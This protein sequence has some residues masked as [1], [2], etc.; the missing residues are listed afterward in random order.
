MNKWYRQGCLRSFDRSRSLGVEISSCSRSDGNDG[1]YLRRRSHTDSSQDTYHSP[2]R[3]T[4]LSRIQSYLGKASQ[5][6][7]ELDRILLSTSAIITSS[8][9]KTNEKNL[10]SG[11]CGADQ[12]Q[13][14]RTECGLVLAKPHLLFLSWPELSSFSSH[15]LPSSPPVSYYFLPSN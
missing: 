7:R 5:L 11:R 1:T 10:G 15:S 9:L 6:G 3:P 13:W 2:L 8:S 12:P 14:R 4:K